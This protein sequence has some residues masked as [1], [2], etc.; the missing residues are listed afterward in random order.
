LQG[1]QFELR[2]PLAK[3]TARKCRECSANVY[4]HARS[5]VDSRDVLA[6]LNTTADT[7]GTLVAPQLMVGSFMAAITEAN[8]SESVVVLNCA[9]S[10]L[11]DFF[12]K[13]R[14]PMDALRAEGRLV[15]LEWDDMDGFTLDIDEVRGAVKWMV[16]QMKH[17]RT[18]LVNCAQGKSRSGTMACAYLMSST[19]VTAAVA[20]A[21]I[22]VARPLVQPNV[23][24]MR[25][26]G[27]FEG[28]L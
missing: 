15:D 5:E 16:E 9:G 27:D 14:S 12:P 7:A 8:K 20:L 6:I 2:V 18:V 10:K 28:K 17:G 13:T 25:Q 21:E 24:F 1:H 22:Q 3:A 23:G 4:A 11:H 19:K 26:L